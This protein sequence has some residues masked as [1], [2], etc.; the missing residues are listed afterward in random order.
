VKVE[1]QRAESVSNLLSLIAETS[2]HRSKLN[3]VPDVQGVRH[4]YS[5]MNTWRKT[6]RLII[7]PL[8]GSDNQ[9]EIYTETWYTS[10]LTSQK[11]T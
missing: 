2:N 7:A 4:D 11:Q 3:Y 5:Q 8:N 10:K 6:G 9:T 1:V